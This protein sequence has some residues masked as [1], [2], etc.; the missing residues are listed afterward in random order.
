MSL[1][2][3]IYNSFKNNVLGF[4]ARKLSAFAIMVCVVAAH[5]SWLKYAFMQNKFELLP[6]ILTI[7]YGFIAVCLGLT[8]W[9]NIKTNPTKKLDESLQ[10]SENKKPDV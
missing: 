9:E 4:S 3:D 1:S 8:T 5:I 2:Q 10:D 6:E 7:D